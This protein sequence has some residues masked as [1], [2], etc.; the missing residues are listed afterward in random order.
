M[1]SVNLLGVRGQEIFELT[2]LALTGLSRVLF[3]T[4]LA[5]CIFIAPARSK[6][7]LTQQLE[8]QVKF[9]NADFRHPIRVTPFAK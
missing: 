7:F 5:A 2:P 6:S 4:R 8:N 9:R 1:G 3:P